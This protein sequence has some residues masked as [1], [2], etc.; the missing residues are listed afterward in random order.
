MKLFQIAKMQKICNFKVFFYF[1][2]AY[3]LEPL[4][5]INHPFGALWR[6]APPAPCSGTSRPVRRHF[7]RGLLSLPSFPLPYHL[8]QFS[9]LL[10]FPSTP[11]FFP[12]SPYLFPL[13]SP[14]RPVSLKVGS[15]H[16]A[17]DLGE[18]CKLLHQSLRWSS[19]RN[20]IWCI[21]AIE[22]D[23]WRQP[24]SLFRI[25]FRINW[26][27]YV[28]VWT[29]FGIFMAIVGLRTSHRPPVLV[30]GPAFGASICPT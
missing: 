21:L 22:S 12:P 18:R 26:P 11:N 1:V 10:P 28:T 30:Y 25:F 13:P 20:R 19:S 7:E 23:L 29:F 4:M 24:F 6:F 2:G 15:L 27:S 3:V 14:F 9:S 8:F 16:P 5:G 17:R